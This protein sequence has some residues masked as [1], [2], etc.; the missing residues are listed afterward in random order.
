MSKVLVVDDQA[1][2]RWILARVLGEQSFDVVTAD[3][4]EQA[5][6]RVKHEAPQVVLMDLKMPRLGGLQALE[7]IKESAPEVPVIVITAYGDVPSAVQAMKL[8]AY[9]FLTK[10]FDNEELLYTVKRAV[11][12]WELLSQVAALKRRLQPGGA[13]RETMGS[14]PKI[15]SV[16]Q[17]I[18]QVA[19]S[20]FTVLIEGETGTGKEIVARAIHQLS[21]RRAMPFIALDCGAIPETLI[22]SELFGYEKGAF[23]GADRRKEG[24]VQLAEKGTLFLDEIANLPLTIQG[25]LLRML[26]ERQILP[27]GGEQ[28]I[29]VDLRIVAASNVRLDEEVQAGRFRRD[30]FHRLNEFAIRI[31]P[32]RERPEDILPLTQRFIDEANIELK[33]HV[34]GLSPEA[35]AV[36]MR[37]SWSGNVRELRNVIRRA[38]LLSQDRI[39][40]EH[41]SGLGSLR[42]APPTYSGVEGILSEG[43]SL[44]EIVQRAAAQVEKDAIERVLRL[45]KGNK[46]QAAR[47]L[48]IDYKTLHYKIKAY[49]I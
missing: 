39:E 18:E 23:T 1:D 20:T 7:Q 9:D 4:G 8:G 28:P 14:S 2:M 10:P 11:E 40:T 34:R 24:H 5:V 3:D 36:L 15:Q 29:A 26:Q 45:T 13:L 6:A 12:R 38:T 25:K 37:Y 31:P 22:E 35:V 27:L 17:Q 32:L 44:K 16:F 49:G 30:L 42:E 41:L 33:K 46:S 48:Q 19:R 21:G 43:L 47:F